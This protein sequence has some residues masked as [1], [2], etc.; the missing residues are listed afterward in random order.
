MAKTHSNE[1]SLM[2]ED[3]FDKK[4]TMES[5]NFRSNVNIGDIQ[6][7]AIGVGNQGDINIGGNIVNN[8]FNIN[9]NEQNKFDSFKQNHSIS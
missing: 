8:I 2:I 1:P 6:G 9:L 7:I 5:K 4:E 3:D